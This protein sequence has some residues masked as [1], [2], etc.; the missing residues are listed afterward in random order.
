MLDGI[1]LE[2]RGIPAVVICT[3]EFEVTARAAAAQWNVPE[4]GVA[5]V[6]HPIANQTPEAL[7]QRAEKVLP[8]V[9][10]LLDL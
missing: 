5:Y 1:Q 8:A 7:Q 3:D 9:E 2:Q 10:R 4:Y 6:E